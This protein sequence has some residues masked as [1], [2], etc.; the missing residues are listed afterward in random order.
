MQ[1]SKEAVLNSFKKLWGG[2]TYN[3]LPPDTVMKSTLIIPEKDG[4][5]TVYFKNKP[6]PGLFKMCFTVEGISLQIDNF[7]RSIGLIYYYDPTYKSLDNMLIDKS[8][9]DK[10]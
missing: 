10:N 5:E 3:N 6:E 1:N 8:K 7:E 9:W 4:T 2:E